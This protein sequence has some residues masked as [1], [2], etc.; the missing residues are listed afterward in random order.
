MGTKI[1]YICL[2]LLCFNVYLPLVIVRYLIS[3]LFFK[4]KKMDFLYTASEMKRNEKQLNQSC[5]QLRI[6]RTCARKINS[7]SNYSEYFM[8][9]NFIRT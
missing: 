7:K 6:Q 2:F 3:K 8:R 5:N 4:W 9:G 1:Q